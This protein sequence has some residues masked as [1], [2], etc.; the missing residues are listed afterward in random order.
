[1]EELTSK[2][3]EKIKSAVRLRD[4]AAQRAS[5]RL[6]FLEGARLC[7]DAAVSGAGIQRCFATEKAASKYGDYLDKILPVCEEYY[8]ITDEISEKLSDTGSGQGIFC[9]CRMQEDKDCFTDFENDGRYIV[10]ENLQDPSNLGAVARTCE[11]LGINALFVCGGCDIYN[12]KAL[13]ASMG[14]LLRMKVVESGDIKSLLTL[15]NSRSVTTYASVPDS[16]ALKLNTLQMQGA[17]AFVVGNE[18]SGMSDAA[19]DLCCARVTIPMKGRAESLN[20]ST[21]AAVIAWEMMR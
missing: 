16:S 11:A 3:N 2:T 12:P 7:A 5:S 10:L 15:M 20:A 21:A 19:K 14:S 8:R 17:V 9:I 4:S 18:G 6:F 13:R 1:M